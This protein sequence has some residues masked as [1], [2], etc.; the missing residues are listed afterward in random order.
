MNMLASKFE[1]IRILIYGLF[2]P[3]V[4]IV[5]GIILCVAISVFALQYDRPV[6][7]AVAGG[8]G[9]FASLLIVELC[10]ELKRIKFRNSRPLYQDRIVKIAVAQIANDLVPLIDKLSLDNSRLRIVGY[11][12][13]YIL[14]ENRRLWRNALSRWLKKG[15][16]VEYILMNP[17]QDVV[18]SF[19]RIKD[20]AK[21]KDGRL[22]I[23][24]LEC[25]DANGLK[26]V[27]RLKTTHPTL[28][29]GGDGTKA[30]WVEGDHPLGSRFAYD[31]TYVP[32]GAMNEGQ[33]RK[34]NEYERMI[35][36]YRRE[37]PT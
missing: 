7:D 3:M 19:T 9:F 27:K 18:N 11:D 14:G 33:N 21:I 25:P 4:W 5:L 8:A 15:L 13:Q 34:F 20:K 12:G 22:K 36:K 32:P 6:A 31:V 29:S 30:M 26:E 17:S 37:I 23:F 16:N 24:V 35:E 1:K 10:C 2:S 28:F